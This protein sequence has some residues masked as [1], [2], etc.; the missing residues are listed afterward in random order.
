[1]EENRLDA[2]PDQKY[3]LIDLV[4]NWPDWKINALTLDESDLKI[5]RIINDYRDG[6]KKNPLKQ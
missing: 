6:G 2:T 4:A 3:S 5:K 1:M